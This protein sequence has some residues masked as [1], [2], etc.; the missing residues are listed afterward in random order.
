MCLYAANVRVP[1]EPRRGHC[2]ALDLELQMVVNH[3][4]DAD[5]G[6][7]VVCKIRRS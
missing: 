4:K 2:I 6:T 3:P 7:W 1:A 5:N